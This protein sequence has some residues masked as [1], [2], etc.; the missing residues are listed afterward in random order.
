M[1]L[2][3]AGD[4]LEY[5]FHLHTGTEDGDGVALAAGVWGWQ[6]RREPVALWGFS[7]EIPWLE[8]GRDLGD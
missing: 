3:R 5:L 4:L 7:S 1:N 2:C 8:H 6:G